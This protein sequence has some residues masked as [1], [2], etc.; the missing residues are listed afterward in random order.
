MENPL[1]SESY[2]K[3]VGDD[4][5][6]LIPVVDEWVTSFRPD[7]KQL[8]LSPPD[9]LLELGEVEGRI[10]RLR[11]RLLPFVSRDPSRLKEQLAMPT[12]SMLVEAGRKDLVEEI[13]DLGGL[14]YVASIL[15]WKAKRKPPG[16]LD[17]S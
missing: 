7:L 16:D 14:F 2:F 4:N 1:G 17:R 3:V 9:G 8:I 10:E 15:G 12:L 13:E 11:E 6:H 5:G